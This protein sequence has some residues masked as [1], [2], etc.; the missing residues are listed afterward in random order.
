MSESLQIRE[1][2][3][4][5]LVRFGNGE[6]ITYILTDPLDAR[7]ITPET[8][9]IV[10]T[11]F[12]RENPSECTDITVINIRDLTFIRTERV[13]LDQLTGERRMAGLRAS[14]DDRLPKTLSQLKLI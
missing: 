8:R 14:S 7:L 11:S 2:L 9:Y 6:T 1:P 4:K 3:H 12:L 5:L 10:V 13:T